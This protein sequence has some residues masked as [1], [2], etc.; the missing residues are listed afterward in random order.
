VKNLFRRRAARRPD[1]AYLTRLVTDARKADEAVRSRAIKA[2]N[3]LD[4]SD[5]NTVATL[6]RATGGMPAGN[7]Y[8]AGVRIVRALG[9]KTERPVVLAA[10]ERERSESE[11]NAMLFDVATTP[12]DEPDEDDVRPL[13]VKCRAERGDW[14][15]PLTILEDTSSPPLMREAA[16]ES[17]ERF[18]A[19]ELTPDSTPREFDERMVRA[20]LE[21]SR[22]AR[23]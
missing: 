2:L 11:I 5:A 9:D 8:Y 21:A 16:A 10:L 3:K 22:H 4:L 7:R 12:P 13:A 1:A 18:V 14:H 15:F 20:A 17:L 23:G 19:G 6:L